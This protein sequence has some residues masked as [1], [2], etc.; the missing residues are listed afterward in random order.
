MFYT[1]TAHRQAHLTIRRPRHVGPS[2]LS[3]KKTGTIKQPG[4]Q[5]YP[6]GC[7]LLQVEPMERR[8]IAGCRLPAR[9]HKGRVSTW[10]QLGTPRKQGNPAKGFSKTKQTPAKPS[11]RMVPRSD[12]RFNAKWRVAARINGVGVAHVV[13]CACRA[14]NWH[15]S[16]GN[17]SILFSLRDSPVSSLGIDT[18]PA[19]ISEVRGHSGY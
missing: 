3:K 14:W 6:S 13:C 10:P 2:P 1:C 5:I 7:L 18:A 9:N 19:K 11:T 15:C 12:S 8:G 17:A 4:T 16:V